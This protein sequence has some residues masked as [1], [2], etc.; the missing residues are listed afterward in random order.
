L[1]TTT[2]SFAKVLLERHLDSPE[3]VRRF[4]EEAQI[5]GQL[6]H[7]GIVPVYELGRLPDGRLYIAMKLIRGRTLAELLEGRAGPAA[8]RARH[9]ATFEQVCQA[10][11]Y[12]HACGVVHRDLKPSNVMVG[13]FGEVQV[14][15]WG[16]AKVLDRGGIADEE[17]SLRGQADGDTVRTLRTGSTADESRAG[18]VE[19][20]E[21]Y[22]LVERDGFMVIWLNRLPVPEVDFSACGGIAG[23]ICSHYR[24]F[25][26]ET[27]VFNMTTDLPVYV[28]MAL[29]LD[30]S[31]RGPAAL[32]GLGSHSHPRV[33]LTKALYE[34]C[35]IRPGEV[36]KYAETPP[37]NRLRSYTDVR[38]LEDHS[39]FFTMPER[40]AELAF[41]LDHGRTQHLDDLPNHSRGSV[42]ENLD[43]CVAALVRAHCRVL[44]ADLTTPDVAGF[45]IRV[46][47][48]LATGLQPI[49]FGHGEERLG[50][51]R[52]Y[53]LPRTLGY[54][55]DASTERDLNPCP[56]PLA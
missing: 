18:S 52:V 14:M 39:A 49:H 30:P 4:V 41:L 12:A 46:V 10:V 6:Q 7:P 8:D 53:E 9:L 3:M 43:V 37:G 45:G 15:D 44:C 2:W 13:S 56:H 31:G 5:G 25:G 35:Q 20:Y 24:R 19:L 32:V 40:R 28:M 17:R 33:A 42:R 54:R 29:L 34:I 36:R 22:E 48:T 55:H 38:T 16:L 50:G 1:P 21:L 23:S 11:A 26:L 51:H 47:R 27:R